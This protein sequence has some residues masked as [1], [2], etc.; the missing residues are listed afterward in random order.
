M[1]LLDPNDIWRFRNIVLSRV[2]IIEIAREYG[3]ALE[4]KDTGTFTHRSFCPFHAG[5]GTGGR[6]R[7]PS[8]FFSKHSNSF[9]CFGC[10]KSGNV[11]DFQVSV[12][13]I[14]L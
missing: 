10:N 7:T 13:Y 6:E 9:C 14:P 12:R 2:S 8:L 4:E 11:L 5:K 1:E 3:I